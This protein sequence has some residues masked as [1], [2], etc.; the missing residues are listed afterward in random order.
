[1]RELAAVLYPITGA[2]LSSSRVSLPVQC[3]SAPSS[4][5]RPRPRR[6]W[7]RRQRQQ[8]GCEAAPVRT[9]PGAG[10][11]VLG[12]SPGS[13]WGDGRDS[14]RCSSLE[15]RQCSRTGAAGLRSAAGPSCA[16]LR[17]APSGLTMM[18]R[19]GGCSPHRGL[20]V[21][22]VACCFQVYLKMWRKI[23]SRNLYLV[24]IL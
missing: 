12:S 20:A 17:W 14:P 6:G 24:Y 7:R 9:G 1:M 8:R 22:V 16:G 3:P 13:G 11:S 21:S 15:T 4:Y 5:R 2:S 19:P 18:Y 10:V 23:A